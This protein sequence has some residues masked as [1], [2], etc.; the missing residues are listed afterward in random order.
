VIVPTAARLGA[1]SERQLHELFSASV[2]RD[3]DR[4]AC[5]HEH[6]TRRLKKAWSGCETRPFALVS[7]QTSQR[8][9]KKWPSSV[10]RPLPRATPPARGSTSTAVD[11]DQRP[12]IERSNADI[13]PL[14]SACVQA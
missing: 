1:Y 6:T 8:K 14:L 9:Q 7:K 12:L 13:R 4:S 3:D 11:T 2:G 5:L 10:A